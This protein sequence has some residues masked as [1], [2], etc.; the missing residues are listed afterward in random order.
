MGFLGLLEVPSLH[1]FP[2][3]SSGLETVAESKLFLPRSVVQLDRLLP[4]L[5]DALRALHICAIVH[6]ECPSSTLR[7]PDSP[8]LLC[9]SLQLPHAATA[10]SLG[11]ALNPFCTSEKTSGFRS[12]SVC[13][14]VSI[15]KSV[16]RL[17]PHLAVGTWRSCFPSLDLF[18][19]QQR[20]VISQCYGKD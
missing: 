20:S 12:Q 9:P 4:I 10:S 7:S 3:R 1:I 5:R 6:L 14:E 15:F 8:L 17:C 16:P 2:L 18:T 11:P 19:H 13:W